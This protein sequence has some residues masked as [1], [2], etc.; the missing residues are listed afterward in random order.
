MSNHSR[1]SA[2]CQLESIPKSK[3]N[4][5]VSKIEEIKEKAVP[6]LKAAGARKAALF[7]SYA[8]GEE[9]PESD[10]DII[11]DM[12]S[13]SSLFDVGGLQYELQ[14]VLGKKVDLSQYVALKP[15]IKPY[16]MKDLVPLM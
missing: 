4:I 15:I 14:E 3:Y 8:R 5:L 7:G 1:L 11:V 2:L 9:T 12:P 13:G 10:I 16:V 6:I